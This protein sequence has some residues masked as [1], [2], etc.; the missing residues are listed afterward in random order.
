MNRLSQLEAKKLLRELEYL[1]SDLEYKS[2]VVADADGRFLTSVNDFLD[3]HKE[4][5]DAFEDVIN[6]RIEKSINM[7]IEERSV[8]PEVTEEVERHEVDPKVKRLYRE[9]AKMTHPD[10][11]VDTRMNNLYL[12][13][14]KSYKG[15]DVIGLF[16]VCE[17]IGIDYEV[18]ESDLEQIR[19]KIQCA[20][21]RINLL[22]STTT[23]V[24][25]STDDD[26]IRRD[27]VVRYVGAQLR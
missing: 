14:G 4:L 17:K 2:E 15:E 13:A 20:K 23:W 21:N 9:I 3:H 25:N 1:N 6:K 27:I 11:I 10:K 22:E 26:G 8:S 19:F 7:S 16:S 24:W 5:K 12:E 18:E